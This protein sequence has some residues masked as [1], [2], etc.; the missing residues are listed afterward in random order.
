MIHYVV[1]ATEHTAPIWAGLQRLVHALPRGIRRHRV[2]HPARAV[3]IKACQGI[4]Q[5]DLFRI[6]GAAKFHGAAVEAVA[7]CA[8]GCIVAAEKGGVSH[9]GHHFAGAVRQ[10]DQN[11]HIVAAL[12]QDHGAGLV[13]P[14]PVSPH[15][16]V[17]HVPV[18]DILARLER[19]DAP[20]RA[21]CGQFLC[22]LIEWRVPQ[23]MAHRDAAPQ[24]LRPLQQILAGG[25]TGRHRFFQ[26]QIKSYSRLSHENTAVLHPA[27]PPYSRTGPGPPGTQKC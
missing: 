4:G 27:F 1:V 16:T 10:P 11:V 24:C 20:Q 17:G 14:A 12:G 9:R 13:R 5:I 6:V 26:Q 23:H 25:H 15:I 7:G 3:D 21:A 8:G 18:A 22:F 19:N 2:L